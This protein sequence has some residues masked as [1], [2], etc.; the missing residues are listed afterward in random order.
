MVSVRVVFVDDG[1]GKCSVLA[2]SLT[3]SEK[4]GPSVTAWWGGEKGPLHRHWSLPRE[5]PCLVQSSRTLRAGLV[6]QPISGVSH[7][8]HLSPAENPDPRLPASCP[9]VCGPSAPP[10]HSPVCADFWASSTSYCSGALSAF[11]GGVQSPHL[12]VQGLKCAGRGGNAHLLK[13]LSLL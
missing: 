4:D 8:G 13:K 7:V 5:A 6:A 10:V 11:L 2:V 12:L 9:C 1:P 3:L